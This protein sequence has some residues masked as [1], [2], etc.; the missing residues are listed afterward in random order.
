MTI[1]KYED[2]KIVEGAV[3][4]YAIPLKIY[5]QLE[6]KLGKEAAGVIT[7]ALEESIK[8]AFEEA[9]E[10][11]QT[12]ISENLKKELATKYDLALLKKDIEKLEIDLRKEIELV[13]KDMKIMT[14]IIV[15]VMVV[16][17]QNSLEFIARLLGLLK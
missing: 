6:E 8:K 3:M 7:K 15:A 16:L 1:V 9:E 10:R 2:D 5:E 11:Q 17:N 4:G 12:V 13:R 14:V